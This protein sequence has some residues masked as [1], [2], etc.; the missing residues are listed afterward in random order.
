MLH[1]SGV[2]N[3]SNLWQRHISVLEWCFMCKRYGKS[4]DHLLLH[5]PIAYKLWSM[6]F[7]LFGIH[8]VMPYKVS[9]LL[10]FNILIFLPLGLDIL[11]HTVN[12]I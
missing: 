6:V 4:V 5:C 7:C 3:G 11:I 10:A 8:W 2:P 9:K 1:E 12:K